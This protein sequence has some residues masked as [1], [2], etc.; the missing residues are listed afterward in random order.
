MVH[1]SNGVGKETKLWCVMASS[2]V[3]GHNTAQRKRSS[4]NLVLKEGFLY[5][6]GGIIKSWTRRYFILNKQ[7]L[8]Y[9]RREQEDGAAENLHPLGRIFLNDIVKIET[10]GVEKKKAFVFALHTKKRAVLLQAANV[11]DKS[12]W[13]A[14]ISR[15]LESEGEAERKDPFR[16]TLRKLAP[17]KDGLLACESLGSDLCRYVHI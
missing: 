8:C 7:S 11:E 13:A 2:E 15:A 6:K 1:K 14:A 12:S 10:D 16:R 3:V 17:G 4:T 5:K 9:F